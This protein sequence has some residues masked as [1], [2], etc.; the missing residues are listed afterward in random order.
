MTNI[1]KGITL[2]NKPTQISNQNLI[3]NYLTYIVRY[4]LC[5]ILPFF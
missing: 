4:F 3:S 5:L 1:T 2:Q